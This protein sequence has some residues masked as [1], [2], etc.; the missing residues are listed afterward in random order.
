LL[1]AKKRIQ[2]LRQ[3]DDFSVI[4]VWQTLAVAQI[5][6]KRE[7]SVRPETK[8]DFAPFSLNH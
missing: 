3:F 6:I 5:K 4:A 2:C 1:L 8:S 7:K